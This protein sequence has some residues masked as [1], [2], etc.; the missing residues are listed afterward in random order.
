[1]KRSLALFFIVIMM[2]SMGGCGGRSGENDVREFPGTNG[3]IALIIEGKDV[4][5]DPYCRA[6]WDGICAYGDQN[7]ITYQWFSAGSNDVEQAKNAIS[8]AIEEGARVIVVGG[9]DFE[10]AVFEMELE[11]LDVSFMIIDG[12]TTDPETVPLMNDNVSG[13]IFREEEA[14]YLAGYAAVM[15]GY[16]KLG[17]LGGRELPSVSRFGC[18]FIQ[19]AED[20]AKELKVASIDMKYQ[21]LGHFD[22]NDDVKSLAQ[23]WYDDGVEVI[24][25]CAG[26]A[27]RSVM[28]AAEAA[29]GNVIGVDV[30]QYED[31]ETVITSAT[32]NLEEAV[33]R[34]LDEYYNSQF[35]GSEIWTM[36]VCDGGVGLAMEHARF[37]TFDQADYDA[38]I[39][40]LQDSGVGMIVEEITNVR[41]MTTKRVRVR[42]VE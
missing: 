27:G 36:D 9:S 39:G 32:K 25:A 29:N 26:G 33:K 16:R 12:P 42:L 31:S 23:S 10:D 40:K 38:L 30:D 4:E 35:P 11:Y 28:E 14:G 21:Y 19:G 41:E 1:M 17:F 34:L 20:A 8:Q 13:V 6:I 3:E 18:G 2:I 24:F 7:E 5:D 37:R 15:D 22:A